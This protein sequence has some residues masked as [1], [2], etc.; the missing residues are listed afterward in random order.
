[1]QKSF[2][3]IYKIKSSQTKK[4]KKNQCPELIRWQQPQNSQMHNKDQP[5][6]RDK[7]AAY[8]TK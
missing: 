1:M 6:K 7:N 4:K 3:V 2:G 5:I 8:N